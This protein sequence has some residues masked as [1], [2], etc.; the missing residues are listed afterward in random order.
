MTREHLQT[1]IREKESALEELR[2]AYEEIQS[3]NEELQSINEELETA[4]EELQSI[5]EELTTVNEE[6]QLRNQE[7]TRAH[8][9]LRNLLAN[10]DIPILMLDLD[11]KIRSYT[12]GIERLLHVIPGDIGRPLSDIRMRVHLPEL[13]E[14]I[15]EAVN[16]VSP[17]HKEVRDDNGRWYSVSVRPYKTG[18]MRIGGAVVS[19]VDI[20]D[21][22]KTA[23]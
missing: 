21:L 2:A 6:L 4:K 20:T 5:N 12:P 13:E 8:D 9:D 22:K 10:I 7:L 17:R 14:M 11:M 15:V 3:S 19:F 1:V 18:D 23:K 16:E